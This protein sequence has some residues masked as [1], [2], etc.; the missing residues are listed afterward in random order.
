E[1]PQGFWDGQAQ[2]FLTWFKPYDKVLDWQPPE[3]RWFEGGKINASY[4]CL[5]RH[6]KTHR[7]DK[8]AI[9]WEGEPGDTRTLT[10]AQLHKEVCRFANALK[11]AGTKKGDRVTIYMPMVPEL[12][13][14]LLACARIGAPHS[15]VFG[16]FSSEA[17]ADR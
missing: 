5:D 9:I 1:D 10:Y 16:G 4:N 8:T 14:A 7:R 3:V 13:V 15:V 17:I 12:A 2:E 6:L 11:K